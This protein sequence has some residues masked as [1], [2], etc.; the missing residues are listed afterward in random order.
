M[1][2][3]PKPTVAVVVPC[4]NDAPLL[5]RCLASF[6]AQTQPADTIIVVDNG[7][8]DNSAHVATS[9]GAQLVTEPRRGI[10]WAAHAGYDAACEWG[11]D[12]IIRTDA[13]AWVDQG[14]VDKLVQA[15]AEAQRSC[16]KRVVGITGPAT[17]ALPRGGETLSRAYLGAYRLSVGSALG[18]PPLFGTNCAFDARWWQQVRGGINTADTF[19]HDDIQLSF[20]VRADE[21]VRYYPQLK[22][23][24]D[25]RALRGA[26]QLRRRFARGWYSM[27][28]GFATDP[29]PKRLL[30][31]WQTTGES[32]CNDRS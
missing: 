13:D 14:Y 4:L 17:F 21:T 23:M 5:A 1:A 22:V 18:H 30:A 15:W 8:T 27:R 16:G 19:V 31:R 28:R 2:T 26:S 24:M 11:A 12:V 25:P 6:A 32:G 20:A 7:S 9:H 29:P 10:T 3:V